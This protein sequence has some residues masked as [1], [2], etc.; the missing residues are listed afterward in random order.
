MCWEFVSDTREKNVDQQLWRCVPG[1]VCPSCGTYPPHSTLHP[2]HYRAQY[3]LV[4]LCVSPVHMLCRR[5]RVSALFLHPVTISPLI[6]A[7]TDMAGFWNL[8]SLAPRLD[9]IHDGWA[10]RPG[11][12][13]NGQRHCVRVCYHIL[14]YMYMCNDLRYVSA[15]EQHT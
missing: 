5:L 1:K 12:L 4:L 8:S 2:A 6:T 14:A 10:S 9:N 15:T 3:T 11:G 7:Q 13:P